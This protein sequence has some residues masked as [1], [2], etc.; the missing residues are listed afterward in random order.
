MFADHW[1]VPK[2]AFNFG[3]PLIM[4]DHY[5]NGVAWDRQPNR[6]Y[7]ALN[8][9]E[10]DLFGDLPRPNFDTVYSMIKLDLSR[11]PVKLSIPDTGGPNGVMYIMPVMDTY[12]NVI[13]TVGWRTVGKGEQEVLIE[14]NSTNAPSYESD[15]SFDV[16]ISTHTSLGLII[17]RTNVISNS[18]FPNTL[19]QI[20]SYNVTELIPD[21]E[22]EELVSREDNFNPIRFLREL[23]GKEF[24][25][26]MCTLMEKNPSYPEDKPLVDRM[27]AY[28]VCNNWDDLPKYKQRFLERGKRRGLTGLF[29]KLTELT[30]SEII[31]GWVMPATDLGNFGTE[32]SLRAFISLFAYGAVS[33]NDALYYLMNDISSRDSCELIIPPSMPMGESG[34]WSLTLYDNR[35]FLVENSMDIYHIAS[36]QDIKFLDDGS[37]LITVSN[38]EPEDSQSN[39][40]PSPS[41]SMK[42]F[43][44]LQFRLYSPK[45]EAINRT[46]VP[47]SCQFS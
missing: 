6:F 38:T 17:G 18:Q 41:R 8:E 4:T 35:G 24:F 31:N 36:Y 15:E 2:E 25:E 45:N 11:S 14:W 30:D 40:L 1:I 13:E 44:S 10:S 20:L 12:T 34:F 5:A 39:W 29:L 23:S 16:H 9:P 33:P 7:H 47:P 26:R 46:W 43:Y 3:L 37:A 32:Y 28:G 19:D 27:E 22:E 42:R 21:L